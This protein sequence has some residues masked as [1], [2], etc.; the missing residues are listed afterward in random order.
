MFWKKQITL[1]WKKSQTDTH[2]AAIKT[3]GSSYS[4][5]RRQKRSAQQVGLA[6]ICHGETWIM[7]LNGK[8]RRIIQDRECNLK[9]LKNQQPSRLHPACSDIVRLQHARNLFAVPL[10]GHLP[11]CHT[12]AVLF[13][14]Q[15]EDFFL[16]EALDEE[17]HDVWKI[18]EG[19][20]VQSGAA[21]L[22]GFEETGASKVK[23][24][25]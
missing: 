16:A 23:H 2:C 21:L 12:H 4:F 15:L 14:Q 19:S 8:Y 7:A 17:V 20:R 5:I 24:A 6:N 11:R 1:I 22:V 10:G 13:P 3:K 18:V 25:Q 9:T